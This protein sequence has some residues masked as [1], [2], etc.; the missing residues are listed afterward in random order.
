M[1]S[2]IFRKKRWLNY[3]RRKRKGIQDSANFS[4]KSTFNCLGDIIK[5]WLQCN[6]GISVKKLTL[7]TVQYQNF[8]EKTDAGY[9]ADVAL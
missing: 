5:T 7:V 9:S 1:A 4:K 8:S 2:C 3:E 6:V